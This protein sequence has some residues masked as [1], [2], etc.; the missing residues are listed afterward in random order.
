MRTVVKTLTVSIRLMDILI[1]YFPL[2]LVLN[3]LIGIGIQN[4]LLKFEIKGKAIWR[5]SSAK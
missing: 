2:Y 4:M 1:L 5:N 3:D